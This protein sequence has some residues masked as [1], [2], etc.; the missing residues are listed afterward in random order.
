MAASA[1]RMSSSVVSQRRAWTE[2]SV[3]GLVNFALLGAHD[4]AEQRVA[5]VAGDLGQLLIASLRA[6]GEGFFGLVARF[7]Q[8]L[9]IGAEPFLS[10]IQKRAGDA[11]T[12]V[13]VVDAVRDEAAQRRFLGR[14]QRAQV[15]LHLEQ[16]L[17]QVLAALGKQVRVG[18]VVHHAG[19]LLALLAVSS[20]TTR[21]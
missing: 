20:S 17:A 11:V 15:L 12:P 13:R 1:E 7:A 6:R 14:Y 18:I 8:R 10:L 5:G 9:G 21:L 2:E 4:Q 19:L 16:V 3:L